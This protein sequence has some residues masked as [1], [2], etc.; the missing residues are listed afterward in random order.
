MG[1]S[2]FG[3]DARKHLKFNPARIFQ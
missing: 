2:P 1:S 3:P